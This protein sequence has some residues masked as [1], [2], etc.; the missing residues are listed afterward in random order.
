MIGDVR[1]W[2][3]AMARE[4]SRLVIHPGMDCYSK[5]GGQELHPLFETGY[6]L[7]VLCLLREAGIPSSA[8]RDMCKA[9]SAAGVVEEPL[10]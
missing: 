8:G 2:S 1:G 4:R 5:S 3:K 7:A 10:Y 9:L 6:M